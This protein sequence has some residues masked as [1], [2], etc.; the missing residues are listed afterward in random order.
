[1][2]R[3]EETDD[4]YPTPSLQARIFSYADT[5]C[6]RLGTPYEALPVNRPRCPV[7]HYHKDGATH[8]FDNMSYPD[9]YYEPN[10]FDGLREDGSFIEPPLDLRGPAA[11]FDHRD[12]NDDFS[13]PRAM[14][15]LFDEAQRARLFA[16]IA[17]AMKEV[18]VSSLMKIIRRRHH[19]PMARQVVVRRD[20]RSVPARAR[21]ACDLGV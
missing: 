1:M 8:F 14:F 12:G 16:N 21:D 5:H 20:D 15:L 17:A 11:R 9:P 7:H 4:A 2:G 18:P 19:A 6:Y 13:Q 10:S 3:A